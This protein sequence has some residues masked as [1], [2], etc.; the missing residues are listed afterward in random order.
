MV[1]Y[2]HTKTG[3]I[4]HASEGSVRDNAMSVDPNWRKATKK[5]VADDVKARQKEEEDDAGGSQDQA[6]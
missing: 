5:E 6:E 4:K 1:A 3:K 2:A